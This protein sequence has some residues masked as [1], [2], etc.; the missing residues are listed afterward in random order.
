MQSILQILKLNDVREGISSKTGKP[1]RMQD[2]ECLLLKDTGEVDQVGVLQIP[3][4]LFGTVNP[5][6]YLGTFAL[7]P[8]M[9]SRRIEAHLTG[10]TP[11]TVK[12]PVAPAAAAAKSG[13]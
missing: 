6:V 5:G 8:N 4:D 3:R 9:A 11:Y 13:A 12:A 7:R 2:A 10:L 1:Y